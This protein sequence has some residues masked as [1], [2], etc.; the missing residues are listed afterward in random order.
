MI[1]LPRLITYRTRYFLMAVAL[2]IAGVAATA[3]RTAY[4]AACTPPG[5]DYGT[6]TYTASVGTAGTYR[7]WVRMAAPSTSVNTVLLDI[8]SATC[9]TVGG[10]S[11]PTYASGTST[12]FSGNTTNWINRTSSDV[13]ISQSLSSGSHTI[14][15]IGTGEGVV[16]DR[17]LFTSDDSCIP[18]GTGDNC[19]MVYLAPD[20]DMNGVVNFLDFSA[21]ANKYGQST[22]TLGR[23]DINRDGTV[24][25]LDFSLLASKYGQ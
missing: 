4:A 3:P 9:Y 19:A 11:V 20:I 25:F 5:T 16:V 23:T 10:S 14:K 2:A 18:T 12:Y 15:L 24:N 22:G 7:I 13:V 6:V 17:V 1:R 21:L 8:D